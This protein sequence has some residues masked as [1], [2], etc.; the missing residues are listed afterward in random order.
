MSN[1]I[2]FLKLQKQIFITGY[3]PHVTYYITCHLVGWLKK[4]KKKTRNRNKKV[5]INL[6]KYLY[7]SIVFYYNT[8]S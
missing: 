7:S 6:L 3:L 2:K 1:K 8:K 5:Y 4:Y